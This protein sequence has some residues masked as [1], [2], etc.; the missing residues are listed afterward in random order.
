TGLTIPP[1][2]DTAKLTPTFGTPLPDASFTIT[3]GSVV[4]ALPTVPAIV[5]GL[6]GAIE[7]GDPAASATCAP[8]LLIRP[9]AE[10]MSDTV[11]AV[12]TI[13][14]SLKVATPRA[15]ERTVANPPIE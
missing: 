1:P 4:T 10:K 5:V 12:P 6:R 2:F 9:G 15:S 14:R 13:D 11:P 7:A 3:L 8:M